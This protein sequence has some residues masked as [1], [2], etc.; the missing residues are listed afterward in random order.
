M[1]NNLLFF[2]SSIFQRRSVWPSFPGLKSEPARRCHHRSFQGVLRFEHIFQCGSSLPCT[3]R[4]WVV[5]V[6]APAPSKTLRLRR[7]TIGKAHFAS[8]RS[9]WWC[10]GR[11]FTD[12]VVFP[13]L[14][15]S[16]KYKLNWVSVPEA[17]IEF[18]NF[19]VFWVSMAV[20]DLWQKFWV[21][22]RKCCSQKPKL[23]LWLQ[24]L[25]ITF[26][27]VVIWFSV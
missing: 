23:W 7:A 8:P 5:A 3:G 18:L 2:K 24:V 20:A 16:L 17:P 15:E 25:C 19:W 11:L 22:C 6:L 27:N 13:Q 10:P 4:F 12:A 9:P 21:F 1:S 26:A 14:T